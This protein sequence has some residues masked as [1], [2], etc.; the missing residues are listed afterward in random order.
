MMNNLPAKLLPKIR[1]LQRDR[2]VKGKK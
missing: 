2:L 1:Q